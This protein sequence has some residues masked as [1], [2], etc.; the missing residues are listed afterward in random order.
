MAPGCWA[1]SLLMSGSYR[2]QLYLGWSGKWQ[3]GRMDS[4]LVLVSY[5]YAPNASL[6]AL[7]SVPTP[8]IK[9]QMTWFLAPGSGIFFLPI[10]MMRWKWVFSCGGVFGIKTTWNLGSD[11]G[12][13]RLIQWVS[14][15]GVGGEGE[16]GRKGGGAEGSKEE[17]RSGKSGEVGRGEMG[18][19]RK[20]RGMVREFDPLGYIIDR[21]DIVALVDLG[22]IQEIDM[23]TFERPCHPVSACYGRDSETDYGGKAS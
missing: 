1:R 13:S 22:P 11:A 8:P 23:P 2:S 17:R 5:E 12:I 16:R 14:R 15:R 19:R 3:V 18:E 6:N 7:R 9:P 20:G 10:S 4:P 21:I